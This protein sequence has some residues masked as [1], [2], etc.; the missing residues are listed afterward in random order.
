MAAG[1]Q[2]EHCDNVTGDFDDVPCND[3]AQGDT[4][5]QTSVKVA[6]DDVALTCRCYVGSTETGLSVYPPGGPRA[7]LLVLIGP[8]L[9]G[10]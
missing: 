7:K 6:K 5:E 9:L 3:G 1:R 4:C 2:V 10:V 8:Y